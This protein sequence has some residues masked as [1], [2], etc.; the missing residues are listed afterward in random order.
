MEGAFDAVLKKSSLADEM[1]STTIKGFDFDKLSAK[2]WEMDWKGLL[3]SYKTS[4]FQATSLGKAI[5]E[6]NKMVFH[7][8]QFIPPIVILETLARTSFTRRS[9]TLP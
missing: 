7:S 5:E 3:D 4:G 2:D 8:F 9:R 6:I 1:K